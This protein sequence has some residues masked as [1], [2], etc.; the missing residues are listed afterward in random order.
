MRGATDLVVVP[1]SEFDPR[2]E[3]DNSFAADPAQRNGYVI[4][5]PK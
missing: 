2:G 5:K 3:G 1:T 4:E